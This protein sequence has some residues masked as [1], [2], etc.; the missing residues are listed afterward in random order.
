ML[1]L[2]VLL[3][4]VELILMLILALLLLLFLILPLLP[5]FPAM[6]LKE[7]PDVVSSGGIKVP[8]GVTVN[9]IWDRIQGQLVVLS[10]LKV[11]PRPRES[12]FWEDCQ[13]SSSLEGKS[14]VREREFVSE[15]K[16]GST[17]GLP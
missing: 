11:G 10:L 14:E 15:L 9:S 17:R 4:L 16:N 6:L 8:S 1:L 5:L 12:E 3:L 7:W 13:P 2:F